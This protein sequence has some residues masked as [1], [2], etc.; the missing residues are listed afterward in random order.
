MEGLGWWGKELAESAYC[1]KLPVHGII[2]TS[3]K[4]N[5]RG[6]ANG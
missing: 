6:T 4:Q 2:M 3:Y 5:S 1:R